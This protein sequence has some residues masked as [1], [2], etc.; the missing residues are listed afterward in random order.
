[1]SR[2]YYVLIVFIFIFHMTNIPLMAVL[3]EQPP[4]GIGTET[5]PWKIETL[6]NL[7]WITAS[8]GQVPDPDQATRWSG[9]YVQ[10]ADINMDGTS[11]LPIG[12][13]NIKFSGSFNGYSENND[14]FYKI[15]N[16][17]IDKFNTDYIGLFG[18]ISNATL[19]NITIENAYILGGQYSGALVGYSESNSLIENITCSG[20]IIS[21]KNHIGGLAGHLFESTL[22]GSTIKDI[23]IRG[24][25][26]T[27]GLAGSAVNSYILN[28]HSFDDPQTS[29]VKV[30]SSQYHAGGLAGFVSNT[31]V[32][33]ARSN[34]EVYGGWAVG[35]LIGTLENGS[36]I[37][38]SFSDGTVNGQYKTGGLVGHSLS[39]NDPPIISNSFSRASVSG[40]SDIGGLIG[41]RQSGHV[42]LSYSSGTVIGTGNNIGGFIGRIITGSTY[43][44][45]WDMEASGQASSPAGI[46][47]TTAE[48]TGPDWN[49][50]YIGWNFTHIWKMNDDYPEFH[51]VIYEDPDYEDISLDDIQ[52]G[53][54]T[55]DDPYKIT[56]A[57]EL[58]AIRHDL[59]AHYKLESDIDLFSTATWNK[60]NGWQPIGTLNDPFTGTFDGNGWTVSNLCINRPK[61]DH[62]GLFGYIVNAN[63]KDLH[64][65]AFHI[66]AG[67]FSGGLAGQSNNSI[68]ENIT[69]NGRLISDNSCIGGLIGRSDDCTFNISSEDYKTFEGISVISSK[70]YIGGVFG[71][72]DGLLFNMPASYLELKSFEIFGRQYVGGFAGYS[73]NCEIENVKMSETKV[74]ST[75]SHAGGFIG[76]IFGGKYFYIAGEDIEVN[77]LY[78]TGGL[79]GALTNHA[80]LRYSFSTGEVHGSHQVGGLAGHMG[81]Q[82]MQT[83]ITDCYS[84]ASVSGISQVGGFIGHREHGNIRRSYS[85]GHVTGTGNN[86]GGFIGRITSGSAL[87]SYYDI[88][89][90]GQATSPGGHGRTSDDMT[91]PYNPE[92]TYI[93][94]NFATIWEINENNIYPVFQNTSK[95]NQPVNLSISMLHGSGT[96]N[97]PYI[98]QNVNEMN[99]IRLNKN[100][101]YVLGSDIDLSSTVIWDKGEGWTPIGTPDN[102]FSGT[103]DGNGHRVINMIINRP[104]ASFQGLF[105]FTENAVIKNIVLKN[106]NI[107]AGN[108]SG[109]LAGL[110]KDSIIENSMAKGIVISTENN[111]GGLIG[112]VLGGLVTRAFTDT[113]VYGK[114]HTGGL[115]G[116][117]TDNAELS[118]SY[119]TGSVYGET[120]VG[121]LTGR[122]GSLNTYSVITNCYSLATV[123][124]DSKIGGLTGYSQ[125][126]NIYYSYST[127]PVFGQEEHIGGLIGQSDSG[128]T[129]HS[130]WDMDTS[131]ISTSAGGLGRT[132]EEMTT[133]NSPN[134]YHTWDFR[135]IWA[136]FS[137]INNGYPFMKWGR[138]ILT[139]TSA[140]ESPEIILS[141][142]GIRL[143]GGLTEISV[144]YPFNFRFLHWEGEN[145][146]LLN[147]QFSNSTFFIMPDH[148]MSLKAVFEELHS[149]MLY[150]EIEND[151]VIGLY[152]EG[153]YSKGMS[154]TISADNQGQYAF[155]TWTGTEEDMALLANPSSSST[156]FF[157]PGRNVSYTAVFKPIYSVNLSAF[158]EHFSVGLS[159]TGNYTPGNPV[160]IYAYSSKYEFM[161]WSGNQEDIDLLDD[162]TSISPSFSMPYRD[163]EFTAVFNTA[164][165][166]FVPAIISLDDAGIKGIWKLSFNQ[167]Y[168]SYKKDILSSG[169]DK[170]PFWTWNK[171]LAG[172]TAKKVLT[173]DI[174][175]N[176]S[177]E[178]I[179]NIPE[180]GLA[181]YNFLYGTWTLIYENCIDFALARTVSG[182]PQSIVFSV[183]Y[184]LYIWDYDRISIKRLFTT[185][186]STLLSADI[187]NNGI[188]E[189][190]LTF[191]DMDSL[192]VYDFETDSAIIIANISPSQMTAGD[193]T[194]D[195]HCELVCAF[196]GHGTYLIRFLPEKYKIRQAPKHKKDIINLNNHGM[197]NK[198]W[199][200]DQRGWEVQRIT[201]AVPMH[202]HEMS[203]AKLAVVDNIAD[204]LIFP[205]Q[206][207]TYLYS[208]F[209]G[210]TDLANFPMKNVIAGRFTGTCYDD[211]I[212]YSSIDN[213]VYIRKTLLSAW[214]VLLYQVNVTAMSPIQ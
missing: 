53:N 110:T 21:L 134:T 23:E 191:K 184:G 161:H 183:D 178:L 66:Q 148:N 15:Q 159:G 93:G 140:P 40:V 68:I 167:S 158:P 202:D 212:A 214:H 210:W 126:A 200:S 2:S 174:T 27:G 9:H 6:G 30:I 73:K 85:N 22:T 120:A 203:T 151:D 26:Y 121:G 193:I 175:G 33:F 154:V 156:T 205:F 31:L 3:L 75:H 187:F 198:R 128:M 199:T 166:A 95:Y 57:N 111:I 35:G 162:P 103:F 86:I 180:N 55:L 112:S 130:Y 117:L 7:L 61:E 5:D 213:N 102:K 89:A 145:A 16:L 150:S 188:D 60:G 182:Q 119:S 143:L 114:D 208:Y 11:W 45:Y 185:P 137:G 46:G 24:R 138:R 29:I 116:N 100:A 69:I 194:G 25:N 107:H 74:N 204:S 209:D 144:T 79:I 41:F 65:Q 90:S 47:R 39:Y 84:H 72:I 147:D 113:M 52:E 64:L 36:E 83:L 77:G 169:L 115:T 97:D 71:Y 163:I 157:M 101:H 189:L 98:I 78:N 152:G 91:W 125:S 168:K 135:K 42:Y 155:V 131:G 56:N 54:G 62:Q 49:N 88:E 171:I 142:G 18:Y 177:I 139:L 81:P 153:F 37:R 32:S 63:I 1:M 92:N 50:T 196:E 19:K 133:I 43:Y 206:N 160:N 96:I 17:M 105:G 13:Q 195:G 106:A 44:S 14:E 201:Y 20:L 108:N 34:S 118:Y 87:F 136:H 146:Y 70:N 132:F 124:G 170:A 165:S 181:Y 99:T 82:N 172:F 123:S 192:Y 176:G 129:F 173:G 58:N 48:M 164:T 4:E 179:M 59:T 207:R 104:D 127:G 149:V 51:E 80:E 141:G 67:G 122:A 197:D 109:A 12:N 190:I 38:Y 10:T 76:L 186:A 94:W 28:S 8:N 211:I